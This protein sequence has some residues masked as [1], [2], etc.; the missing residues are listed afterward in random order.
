MILAK[1]HQSFLN[2]LNTNVKKKMIVKLLFLTKQ[3]LKFNAI[4]KF[5]INYIINQ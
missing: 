4:Y 2:V 5:S 1:N 3:V